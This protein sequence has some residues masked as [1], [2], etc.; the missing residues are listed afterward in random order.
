MRIWEVHDALWLCAGL[1]ATLVVTNLWLVVRVLRPL[2]QL[3]QQANRVTEGNFAALEQPCGGI[4]EVEALRRSL[5]AMVGHV[6]RVQDQKRQYSDALTRGQEAERTRI[7]RE[8]HDDTMQSLIG[9]AQGIDLACNWINE[10]PVQSAQMLKDIRTQAVDA[11]NNLRNMIADLRPPALE[12]LGLISALK[13]LISKSNGIPVDVS[14]SGV[15]RRLGADQELTLFRSVQEALNNSQQHS[16]ATRINIVV[17][18]HPEH[19]KLTV[20]DNGRGFRVPGNLD[21]LATQRHYGLV[22]IQERVKS[23]QGT[24]SVQS[25]PGKGTQVTADIPCLEENQPTNDV[26]DPVCSAMVKPHQAYGSIAYENQTY[27]F[28]CPVCQG[29]FQQNPSRYLAGIVQPEKSE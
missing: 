11:V 7:A 26:R 4:R 22:G 18:Y 2:R 10:R 5:F 24:L 13:M 12:E 23:L 8:L 21:Q 20:S 9:I 28:C 14:I 19:I 25:Q 3:A 15:E 16:N 1:L 29:A 27:Y 17:D 6:R